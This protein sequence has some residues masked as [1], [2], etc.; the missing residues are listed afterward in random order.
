MGLG[1]T[2]VGVG[3]LLACLIVGG[4]VA[5][6]ASS[7]ATPAG[8]RIQVFVQPG[9]GQGNG[10]VLFTGAVGDYGSSHP[11]SGSGGKKLALTTL[12][13]GTIT[14]DLT[15]INKKSSNGTPTINAATCS[16]ALTVSAP[17]PVVSGTGLYKGIHGSVKLT[18]T[19]GFIGSTYKSG[20]KKG[21]CNMSNS[22]ATVAQMAT[23]YG[24]GSVS[25]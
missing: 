12:K 20:P 22:S 14:V 7:S 6:A 13:K 2:T 21:Q 3:G 10:K 17:V 24:S 16:G 25:F 8:G 15:A 1:K 5:L 23:V 11:V 19:Y 18:E 9:N 4:S